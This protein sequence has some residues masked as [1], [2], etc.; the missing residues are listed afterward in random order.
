MKL[1]LKVVRPAIYQGEGKVIVHPNFYLEPS[2]DGYEEYLTPELD[3]EQV[4]TGKLLPKV[5]VGKD[6][7]YPPDVTKE[8]IDTDMKKLRL[9]LAAE[10]V[11]ARNKSIELQD[12]VGMEYREE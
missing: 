7:V 11:A 10:F 1:V 5:V 6:H 12:M 3:A 8:Q 4:P 2:D 9:K